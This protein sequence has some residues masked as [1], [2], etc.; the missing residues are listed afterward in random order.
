LLECTFF[1]IWQ[2]IEKIRALGES[3]VKIVGVSAG[4]D[5]EQSFMSAGADIF[6]PKPMK[7]DVVEPIIQEVMNKKNNSM[8]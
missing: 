6:L 5:L 1:L 7:F 4:Y 2:A 3:H 8:V